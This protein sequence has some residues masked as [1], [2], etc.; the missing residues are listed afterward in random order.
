M[1]LEDGRRS[2]GQ[3]LRPARRRNPRGQ[4]ARLRD[5]IIE[6]AQ[7]IL[8]RTGTEQS[9]TLR[10]V[11][12]EAGIAAPS[13][14]PHFSD[15]AAIIDA[16]IAAAVG[17]LHEQLALAYA[18]TDDPIERLLATTRAYYDYGAGHPGRY[19]V[20]TG[21]QYLSVWDDQDRP[22][23]KTFPLML[24]SFMFVVKAVQGCIDAGHSPSTDA[25]YDATLLWFAIHGLIVL[26]AAITSLP[27]PDRESVLRD[28]VQRSCQLDLPAPGRDGVPGRGSPAR[29]GAAER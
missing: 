22:M 20:L 4:G 14:A 24:A 10:S 3:S 6:A 7:A 21:R 5:E 11:A 2:V 17:V 8:E 29:K 28:C 12:R 26:P 18:S 1:A 15:P 25:Y 27:W 13:I 9:I 16:A 19:R 23:T